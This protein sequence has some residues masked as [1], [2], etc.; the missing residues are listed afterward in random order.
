[1]NPN[2]S[3]L[4]ARTALATFPTNYIPRCSFLRQFKSSNSAGKRYGTPVRLAMRKNRS[5]ETRIP[6][7]N[8][9]LLH[10]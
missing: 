7:D 5:T 9:L 6:Q 3:L 2:G 1:M 4:H 8:N 10:T